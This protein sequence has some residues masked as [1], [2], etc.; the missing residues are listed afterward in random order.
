MPLLGRVGRVG[1]HA[2]SGSARTMPDA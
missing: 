1:F 2:E